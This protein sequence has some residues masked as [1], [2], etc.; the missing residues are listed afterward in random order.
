MHLKVCVCISVFWFGQSF[1]VI[2][3]LNETEYER[4]PRLFGLENYEKCMED[5]GGIYCVA[6]LELYADLK[7]ELYTLIQEYSEF[8]LKHYNYSRIDRGVCVTQ[9]CKSYAK[10]VGLDINRDLRKVLEGCLNETIVN[11]YNLMAR[12][13]NMNCVS[14]KDKDQLNLDYTDY[15]FL[16][17]FIIL[18]VLCLVGSYC[19]IYSNDKNNELNHKKGVSGKDILLCFSIPRNYKGLTTIGE[20]DPRVNIFKSIHALRTIVTF[21]TAS[22]HTALL[23][24]DFT[25]DPHSF[26]KAYEYV[27]KRIAF[28]G[29]NIVQV[30][31]FFTGMLLTYFMQVSAETR[32]VTWN[33]IPKIIFGRWWRLTPSAAMVVGFS[34]TWMRHLSSGPLWH[35]HITHGSSAQCRRFFWAHVLYLNNYIPEDTFCVFQTWYIAAD[36]Q[37]FIVGI[38]IHFAIRNRS[39]RFKIT[40]LTALL[41]LGMA[42]PALHVWWL[43]L[44]AFFMQKPE[45]CRTLSDANFR[46]LHTL[47]HNNL[48]GFIIGLA[49]GYF[50]YYL[51]QNKL[52]YSNFKIGNFICWCSIPMYILL[53]YCGSLFFID[54]ERPSIALRMLYAGTNRAI[55]GFLVAFGAV[56]STLKFNGMSK[57]VMEWPGWVLPSRLSYS[58]YLLHTVFI[59]LSLGIRTQ[60]TP[61][62]FYNTFLMAVGVFVVT[63]VVAVPFHLLVEAPTI[64]LLKLTSSE[65]TEKKLN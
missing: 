51:Q 11:K 31:F 40:T 24:S 45:V 29:T 10:Y 59:E 19:E 32:Q 50:V 9:T 6:N 34:A 55:V 63:H 20:S 53:V 57:A 8:A 26:E 65:K 28:S 33:M 58:V 56:G 37:L 23:I 47:G 3:H 18:L 30:F 43:D 22:A 44:D 2:Y 17:V 64:K 13:Y 7:N 21:F 54:G 49:A 4:L 5:P 52:E 16:G 27:D 25:A 60:L 35:T 46:K 15:I 62:S 12:M 36:M 61:V 48:S 42:S 14:E 41:L 38:L 1:G 39:T